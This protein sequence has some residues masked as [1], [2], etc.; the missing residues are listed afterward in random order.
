VLSGVKELLQPFLQEQRD[1]LPMAFSSL[2]ST[3][4]EGLLEQVGVVEVDGNVE[5]SINVPVGSPDCSGFDYSKYLDENSGTLYLMEHHKTQL[6]KLGIPFG[7]GGYS[8]YDVRGSTTCL[9]FEVSGQL[10]HGTTDCCL[11]PSGLLGNSPAKLLRIGF[12]HKKPPVGVV[13]LVLF[14]LTRC[15]CVTLPML[16][17]G[18]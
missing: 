15:P 1:N 2:G 11:A 18:R 10:Y 5:D 9:R 16:Y 13:V 6:A 3:R 4:A 8:M 14:T 7:R 12:E 17:P